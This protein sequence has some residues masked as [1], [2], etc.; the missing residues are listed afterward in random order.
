MVRMRLV[1]VGAV[2]LSCLT[3]CAFDGPIPV[4]APECINAH[5]DVGSAGDRIVV[6]ATADACRA[7]DGRLLPEVQSFDTL[8]RSV[9]QAPGPPIDGLVITV[10]RSAERPLGDQPR[11]LPLTSKQAT[12]RWGA[13]PVVQAAQEQRDLVRFLCSFALIVVALI[14]VVLGAGLFLALVGCMRR[15]EIV[16]VW[17]LR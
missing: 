15:G 17:F 10:G 1:I 8:G 2:V 9:W 14:V 11:S 7:M 5:G 3:A 16:L 12:Q 6:A 4:R 13:H